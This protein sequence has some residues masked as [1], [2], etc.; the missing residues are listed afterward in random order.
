MGVD[1]DCPVWRVSNKNEVTILFN[2]HLV[3]LFI[4]H[5]Q[6]AT[7]FIDWVA[8]CPAKRYLSKINCSGLNR[9]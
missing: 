7:R 6:F 4:G 1:C 9:L 5:S 8:R 3:L 2:S